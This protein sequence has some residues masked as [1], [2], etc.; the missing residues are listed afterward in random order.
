MSADEIIKFKQ[1]L[2]DGIINQAEFNRKKADIL[3][4]NKEASQSGS[5]GLQTQKTLNVVGIVLLLAFAALAL[6]MAVGASSISFQ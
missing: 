5:D 4:I 3:G 6:Y 1:M 2:D